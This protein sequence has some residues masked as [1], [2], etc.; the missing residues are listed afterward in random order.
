MR[1]PQYVYHLAESTNWP[2][3]QREGLHSASG[4]IDRAGLRGKTRTS[5]ERQQ[6]R[7]GIVLPSGAYLRDQAPMPPEALVRCLVGMAPADWYALINAHVFFWLDPDR[8]NRQRKACGSRPQVV[9]TIDV[10]RLVAAYTAEI[11]LTPIN[12][13]N[14]RRQPAKRSTATFVPYAEWQKTAWATESAALGVRERPRSHAPVE[15]TVRGSVPNVAELI[16]DVHTLGAGET[17]APR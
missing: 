7:E 15:L 14:A 9:L 10:A 6:R 2:A 8:L 5:A 3:I 17:F 4:L 16:V 12:T 1:L 11:A 13:G